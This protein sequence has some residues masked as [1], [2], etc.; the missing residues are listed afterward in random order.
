MKV[1]NGKIALSAS[2]LVGYLNCSH[3]SALDLDV[4]GGTRE[5][6][7]YYDPLLELL[8]ER[9]NKHEQA[10]LDH[11]Q[12]SGFDYVLIDGVDISDASVKAT[13]S[14]MASGARIIVQA[15]LRSEGLVGRADILKRIEKP[16]NF[17][18]WSYE[19]IDTKLSRET[20]G[21]SILQLCLYADL[22]SEAQGSPPEHIYIVAPW[23]DFEP[24]IFRFNDY[25]AYYRKVKAGALAAVM[26]G[27]LGETYP[28][29]KSHCDICRW[30]SDCDAR[31]RSDDHLC[32][33]ANISKNQISEFKRN[34]IDTVK[35]LA[36]L[37]EKI[38]SKKNSSFQSMN[39]H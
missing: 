23:S 7:N 26:P 6:P 36:Q 11:L 25:S 5:K 18:D 13:L 2:D 31:R 4:L 30:R 3:L 24:Q 27:G 1:S 10:Y 19:I 8:K 28:E 21:G 12:S 33:V 29:P 35:A 14:A 22:L 15:A 37:P 32:L 34:G 9:G 17:G 38:D 39:V 20:K 16:S